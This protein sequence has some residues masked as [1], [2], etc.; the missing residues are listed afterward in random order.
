M[1]AV[2]P[3]VPTPERQKRSAGA[4]F[5]ES[6]EEEMRRVA[7]HLERRNRRVAYRSSHKAMNGFSMD[8]RRGYSFSESLG[9]EAGA[10]RTPI[11][12]PR[13]NKSP[14]QFSTNT[15]P[16]LP[17]PEIE[18]DTSQRP[19]TPLSAPPDGREPPLELPEDGEEEATDD[20]R[21]EEREESPNLVSAAIAE[22]VPEVV[23]R[24]VT[25]Q[26]PTVAMAEPPVDRLPAEEGPHVQQS[27]DTVT[28]PPP[29]GTTPQIPRTPTPEKDTEPKDT[30]PETNSIAEQ[31]RGDDPKDTAAESFQL[32]T[33]DT[34]AESFQLSTK[35]TAAESLQLSTKDTAAESFQLSTKD[36]SAES[37]QL[38]TKDT[39]AESFQ[40]S[41]P[42]VK[43]VPVKPSTKHNRSP[44]PDVAV[45]PQRDD[46]RHSAIAKHELRSAPESKIHITVSSSVDK[47]HRHSELSSLVMELQA[48]LREKEEDMK[49]LQRRHDREAKEKDEHIKKMSKENHRL[50]R[51]KWEL[52]K[53][54]RDA[55]ERSLHLRTQLDLKEGSFRAAQVELE[56]SR[57]ELVSVKSAN[58]S[59]RSLLSD[60]RAPRSSVDMAVQVDLG[61][62]TLRRNRSIE[63]ALTQGLS[64]DIDSGVERSGEF[65]MSSSTIG[66]TWSER[67]DREVGRCLSLSPVS[68]G[69]VPWGRWILKTQD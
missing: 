67:W 17:L 19:P 61:G 64:E 31:S 58:T 29:A 43:S 5:M 33:K 47:S 16:N 27:S 46:H 25:L 60:L 68:V 44:I 1:A 39:S 6:M 22:P 38:S 9:H 32:S 57:D 20:A 8:G 7:E 53:R 37:L 4:S 51:E 54:A 28:S 35:D 48:Q 50:E 56:R 55:A 40:L 24:A 23:T 65:R 59:L 12:R 36:T 10:R 49:V 41:T 11:R 26:S 2:Q 42:E 62:G 18:P 13:I 45:K 30:A 63:L 34:A 69:A 52:L 15:L 3:Q 14:R 21:T 66:E